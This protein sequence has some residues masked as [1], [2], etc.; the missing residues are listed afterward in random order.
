MDLTPL[1]VPSL[2][3]VFVERFEG[4]IL[5]GELAI[6]QRLPSERELALQ[7]GVSRPVVH[8]GLAQLEARGLV[9]VRPRAR[10]EVA[11]YR[12]CGS[13]SLL[14]SLVNHQRVDVDPTLLQ[15]M[16]EMRRLVE[17]ETA[18]CAALHRTAED[19]RRLE[20]LIEAEREAPSRDVVQVTDLD[21]EVHHTVALASGNPVYPLLIKSFEPAYKN[22]S[23]QF[24]SEPSVASLVVEFHGQLLRCIEA[25]DADG[26]VNVMEQLLDHGQR[27]LAEVIQHRSS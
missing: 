16:L 24:F 20:T 22:F 26:A 2:K 9:T 4:L 19:V 5:S 11:D 23:G 18:R 15:G 14:T 25:R 21:F 12:R 6:G 27:V 7:L 1:A 3:D 8:A 10:A 13:L 17:T